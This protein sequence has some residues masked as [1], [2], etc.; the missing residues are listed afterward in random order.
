VGLAEESIEV[1]EV[2]GVVAVWR[3]GALQSNVK[4]REDSGL[5]LGHVSGGGDVMHRFDGPS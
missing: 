3:S 4:A 1:L 2:V 5:A